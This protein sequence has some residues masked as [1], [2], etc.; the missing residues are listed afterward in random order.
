MPE[1]YGGGIK[2]GFQLELPH[3]GAFHDIGVI[4]TVAL[5]GIAQQL[6]VRRAAKDV[7]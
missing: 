2:E 7:F 6:L 4:A 3:V 1:H 5:G